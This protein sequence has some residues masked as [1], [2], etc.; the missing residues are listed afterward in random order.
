M[1]RASSWSLRGALCS[2]EIMPF[3]YFC[4]IN[5]AEKLW[6]GVE[7]TTSVNSPSE[8][9]DSE[10]AFSSVLISDAVS[11]LRSNL[12]MD[13]WCSYHGECKGGEPKLLKMHPEY[14]EEIGIQWGSG[15]K[16]K[17]RKKENHKLRL[18]GNSFISVCGCYYVNESW[19]KSFPSFTAGKFRISKM[20]SRTTG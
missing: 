13:S 2:Q 10:L 11:E 17:G 14:I 8:K 5:Q 19:L 20:R 15:D 16:A 6:G 18:N 1:N 9:C 12:F 7:G 3:S 4:H